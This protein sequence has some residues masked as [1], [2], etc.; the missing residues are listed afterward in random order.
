[1]GFTFLHPDF[2]FESGKKQLDLGVGRAGS[3]CPTVALEVGNSKSLAQL[4]ID[5]KFWLEG[6]P[7]VCQLLPSFCRHHL[8]R[9]HFQV[10][11]FIIVLIEAPTPPLDQNIAKIIIQLWR[12]A[13]VDGQRHSASMVWEDDWSH[14]ASPLYILLSDIFGDLV[15]K[16]YGENDR[17]S[18]NTQGWRLGILQG[19]E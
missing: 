10:R 13:G 16:E 2:Y 3:S 15:P 4:K 17:V 11:L 6:P 9:T 14:A 12:A 1:V 8:T 5:A 7:Q 18:V 19:F